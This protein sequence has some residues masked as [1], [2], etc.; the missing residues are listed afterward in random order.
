G[1]V[2]EANRAFSAMLGYSAEEIGC[3]HVW[4]WD[5]QMSREALEEAIRLVDSSGDH[6]VTRHRRKDG[7]TFDVEITSTATVRQG[8]KLIFCACRDISDRVKAEEDLRES[9]S[10]LKAMFE[11]ASIGVAQADPMT[12][13]WLHV[14]Q[15]LCEIT[16][17]SAE[18]MLQ[19]RVPEITHPDDR[20]KDWEAFQD[21]V[22]GR[23]KSYRIEK[24]YIRKDGVIIW[25]N[26]NMT[27][28]RDSMGTPTRTMAAIEDVSERKQA[29]EE[30]REY[31]QRLL[32]AQKAESLG[33]MAM[34]IAHNF[35]NMLGVVMGN[36]ELAREEASQ[37]SDLQV[38]I[39]EAMNASE[40][41][42]KISRFM[43]AYLG[44]ST[45][46]TGLLDF[47]KAVREVCVR[48]N[49]SIPANVHLKADLPDSGPNIQADGPQ[50][51]LILNNLLSNAVE[52]IGEEKGE[53]VL[54]LDVLPGTALP[55]SKLLPFGFEPKEKEYACLSIVDT[56]VGIGPEDLDSIFDP[57]FSTKFIGRGL[58]LPVVSGLLQAIGGAVSV[59]SQPG[60]GSTFRVF[61]PLSGQERVSSPAEYVHVESLAG[62]GGPV[63]V[64]DDEAIFRQMAKP[65]LKRLLGCDAV[66]AGDG[67]EA[68]K[69]FRMYKNEICLVLLD[70][71]M[72]G[73]DGWQTLSALRAIRPDIPV[74]LS[75]GFDEV[76]VSWE[77]HPEH[78]R[79]NAFLP[80]PY[81]MRDLKAALETA[82]NVRFEENG[83]DLA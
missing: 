79:P 57:F 14:N 16:G 42:A 9:E 48:F 13:Q 1:K 29:E 23:L 51:T 39:D 76:Q 32:Q 82:L 45:V 75:S 6:F 24:R 18:E 49:D 2:F 37:D 64:V 77:D 5:A 43:L 71:S 28:I 47:A 33:R 83:A 27:V 30:S 46:R 7:S 65:M 53:I 80:K 11:M 69:I 25:V 10:R 21:V 73:M 34:A 81:G 8:K 55:E 62:G 58:G 40:R 19:L 12:G 17:Y 56:G 67:L 68:L 15:K 60:Q 50:L 61:V 52:A 63:L 54:K 78:E 22:A 38:C 66:I 3:L 20:E 59:E 70:I 26:V 4:D 44:Q 36:L 31:E 72:P 41:A 74:I 35:N